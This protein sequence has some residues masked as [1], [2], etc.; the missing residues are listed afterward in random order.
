MN[1]PILVV[2]LNPTFQKT[3][4]FDHFQ[5]NEVNRSS[6]YRQDA[7][8]KGINVAR[9][10]TQLGGKAMHLTHLGGARKDEMISLINKDKIELY[11][12]EAESEIRTCTTIINKE[13]NTTTELVEEAKQLIQ[14]V[15]RE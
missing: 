12:I 9:I 7:S 8:G 13:K 3:L 4:L 1:D 10:I 15:M 6:M 2:C 11:Y 5:E 14:R